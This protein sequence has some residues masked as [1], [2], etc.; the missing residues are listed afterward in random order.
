MRIYFICFCLRI[1][2]CHRIHRL[3]S[4]TYND[5]KKIS[6]ASRKKFSIFN[7]RSRKKKYNNQNHFVISAKN[8]SIWIFI[9][10]TKKK[11][12]PRYSL[13]V[14]N[15]DVSNSKIHFQSMKNCFHFRLCNSYQMAVRELKLKFGFFLAIF[16]CFKNFILFFFFYFIHSFQRKYVTFCRSVPFC[17]F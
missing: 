7:S 10:H 12:F 16:I 4:H 13:C 11:K 17:L 8:H 3:H 9:I 2:L 5:K 15:C 1:H 6:L 14:N